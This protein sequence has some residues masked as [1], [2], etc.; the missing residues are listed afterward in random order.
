MAIAFNATSSGSG[1]TNPWSFNH[2]CSS[3]SGRFLFVA[4]SASS[5]AGPT[6]VTYN[7]SAMTLVATVGAGSTR[8]WYLANP[9]SGT[10]SLS[11]A[12]AT[13]NMQAVA[14]SYTGSSGTGNPEATTN[15][16]TA[17]PA[18]TVTNSVTTLTDNSWVI[19]LGCYSSFANNLVAGAGAT[20]RIKQA[21]GPDGEAIGIFDSNSPKTP[22]GS[23]SMTLNASAGSG[24]MVLYNFALKIET[25][26]NSSILMALL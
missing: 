25:V 13:T 24:R 20:E 2:T 22:A 18:T 16:D 17:S 7:G 9:S 11:F 10:N 6:G 21:S 15:T 14:A 12:G 5:G 3:L 23:Y 8:F 19:G 26:G 4:T 1:N